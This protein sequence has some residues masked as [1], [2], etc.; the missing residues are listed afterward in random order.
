MSLNV[1]FKAVIMIMNPLL[2]APCVTYRTVRH[3]GE[4]G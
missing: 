3:A 4:K 1:F 2:F